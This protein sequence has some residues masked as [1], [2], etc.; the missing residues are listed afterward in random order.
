MSQSIQIPIDHSLPTSPADAYVESM[1]KRAGT[2]FFWGM[3]RLEPAR[4]RG[5]FSVYAFCRDVDDIADGDLPLDQKIALLSAWR[6]EVDQIFDGTATH[7]ISLTVI[8]T[9]KTFDLK[10]QDFI[11]VIDGM[12]MDAHPSVRIKDLAELELYCDR[13]ACA[14]GRLCVP[15]FGLKHDEGVELSRALGLALQLTNI[16]RDVT[17]DAGRDRVYLPADMLVEAGAAKQDIETILAAPN[18]GDVCATLAARAGNYFEQ[19]RAIT[20]AADQGAARPAIMMMEVYHRVY[21]R[22]LKR[23]WDDLSQDVGLSKLNKIFIAIR[24]G[25][26]N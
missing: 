13:V 14:V 23:G 10:R 16:L 19:A 11:D 12:E 4:R 25:L 22:L 15:I 18:L 24:Y 3:R 6:N 2:S 8:E 9:L 17:E 5:V 7:P 20:N 1:V 26:F 21:L